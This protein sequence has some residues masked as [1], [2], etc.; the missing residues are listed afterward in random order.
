MTGA[1]EKNRRFLGRTAD[2][3]VHSD[4]YLQT[5][6]MYVCVFANYLRYNIVVA[7]SIACQ[8]AIEGPRIGMLNFWLMAIEFSY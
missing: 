6:C 4:I 8:L 2:V 7:R 1:F 3:R 5:A